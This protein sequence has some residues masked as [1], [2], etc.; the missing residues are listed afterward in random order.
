MQIV[1]ERTFVWAFAS[2]APA[3]AT[4]ERSRTM[5]IFLR[6]RVLPAALCLLLSHLLGSNG[7]VTLHLSND[8]LHKNTAFIVI[9]LVYILTTAPALVLA[10]V[11]FQG[12][13]CV[14]TTNGS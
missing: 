4:L 6:T 3:L 11:T 5:R 7:R 8:A 9:G 2:P 14:A 12:T 13:A 1:H 10:P